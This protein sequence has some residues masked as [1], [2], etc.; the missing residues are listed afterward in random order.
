MAT[1]PGF[2]YS[3]SEESVIHHLINL[4]LSDT[5]DLFEL[6]DACAAYVSVLVETDDAVTFSTLCTRL[7]ATLKQLR[8]RC[9]TELPPYLVE[10]LIAGEKM[11][12]C[13]PDCWQETTLQ[14]DYAVALTQAVMGGTLP[15][16]V[17]KELTG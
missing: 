1:I 7:L 17:A 5:A 12:S 6:A 13:V 14:V 9:D 3:L 11:A 10:Q 2:S 4:Q 8:G 16:S 15:T